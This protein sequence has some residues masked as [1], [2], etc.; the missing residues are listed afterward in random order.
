MTVAVAQLVERALP[1]KE[2][3]RTDP[4]IGKNYI[5]NILSTV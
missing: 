1:T 2:G 4:V 3:R 5:E